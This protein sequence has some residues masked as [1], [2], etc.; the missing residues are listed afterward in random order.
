MIL[1]RLDASTGSREVLR[2]AAVI[3]R[4]FPRQVL[5]RVITEDAEGIEERIRGLGSVG[6]IHNARVWPEVIYAFRHALTREVAYNAQTRPSG[7]Y[8]T[9]DR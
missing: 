3:G 8:S 4:E 2:V 5:E 6:R 7:R 9:A 1:G